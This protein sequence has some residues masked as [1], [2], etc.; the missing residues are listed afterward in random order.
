MG[1]GLTETFRGAC[2]RCTR[3]TARAPVTPTT[4]AAPRCA[5]ATC[6]GAGDGGAGPRGRWSRAGPSGARLAK[7]QPG[8]RQALTALASPGGVWTLSGIDGPYDVQ[9]GRCPAACGGPPGYLRQEDA[10]SRIEWHGNGTG[11]ARG[12]HGR[13]GALCCQCH[14]GVNSSWPGWGGA[15]PRAGAGWGVRVGVCT[16]AIAARRMVQI[17]G[18]C[19]FGSA[20]DGLFGAGRA[21]LDPLAG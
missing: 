2:A 11:M 15:F 10:W 12:W 13:A 16:T 17:W 4:P 3:F 5:S 21:T 14:A 1:A 20:P 9:R 8:T 18:W 6:P 19:R 7:R